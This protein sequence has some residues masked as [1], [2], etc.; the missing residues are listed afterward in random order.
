MKG[1][2]VPINAAYVKQRF[3]EIADDEDLS[4]YILLKPHHPLRAGTIVAG[5]VADRFLIAD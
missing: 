3:E 1:A 2:S 5:I 4:R